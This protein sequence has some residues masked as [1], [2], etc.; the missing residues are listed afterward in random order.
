MCVRAIADEPRP[1]LASS[2]AEALVGPTSLVLMLCSGD[3]WAA[4]ACFLSPSLCALVL[5]SP[6]H[7][8][9]VAVGCF[10]VDLSPEGS[11]DE[12]EAVRSPL[13]SA[14]QEM[15]M[16]GRR[17]MAQASSQ[18]LD[19]RGDEGEGSHC[20]REASPPLP[21]V[22]QTSDAERRRTDARR[23]KVTLAGIRFT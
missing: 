4:V 19:A 13:C 6:Y 7:A 14:P 23:C 22:L 12:P 1:D 20:E 11:E 17:S 21:P 18:E 15:A 10:K 5:L 16:D 3:E 8:S 9:G 2:A